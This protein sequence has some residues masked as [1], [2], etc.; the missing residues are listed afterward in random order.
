MTH[1]KLLL[2][3]EDLANDPR[4]DPPTTHVDAGEEDLLNIPAFLRRQ[5]D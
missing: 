2:L 4:N 5:A 3:P 1:M